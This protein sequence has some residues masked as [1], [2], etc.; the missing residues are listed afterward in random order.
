MVTFGELLSYNLYIDKTTFDFILKCF[1]FF[2]DEPINFLK[3]MRQFF[4]SICYKHK[5]CRLQHRQSRIYQLKTKDSGLITYFFINQKPQRRYYEKGITQVL[6]S[7]LCYYQFLSNFMKERN[8]SFFNL[9]QDGGEKR[10]PYHFFP[11]NFYKRRNQFL[12]LSD[13]QF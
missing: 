12:K 6:V 3:Q 9:I 4:C 8:V 5:F 7:V 13:F 11:F 10:P 2:F 1:T